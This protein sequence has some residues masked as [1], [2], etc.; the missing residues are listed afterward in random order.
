MDIIKN[1]LLKKE[2]C[3]NYVGI[4][5]AINIFSKK[6][7]GELEFKESYNHEIQFVYKILKIIFLLLN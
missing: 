6:D 5:S 1:E 4:G 7:D 3:I 2:H